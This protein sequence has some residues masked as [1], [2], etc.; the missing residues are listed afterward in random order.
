MLKGMRGQRAGMDEQHVIEL[1]DRYNKWRA[2]YSYAGQSPPDEPERANGR[3]YF[4]DGYPYPDWSAFIIETT[5]DGLYRV[6]HA[7]TERRNTP[8]ES[9]RA[10][11]SQFKDA[12]KY[13]IYEVADRLR[14]MKG[15]MPLER[16]WRAEG[17]DARVDKISISDRQAKYLLREDPGAYFVAYSGGIQ[18]YN[19]ILPMS[20][21]EL[22]AALLDGFPESVTSRLAEDPS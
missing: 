16:K 15:L 20:Y 21:D 18:P 22:E 13:L 11:F 17:L 19:H 2:I 4:R 9:E 14:G 5:A 8:L 10:V 7:S 1:I 3:L 12:G 6:L